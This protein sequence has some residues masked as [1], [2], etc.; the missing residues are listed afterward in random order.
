VHLFAINVRLGTGENP[1]AA[2]SSLGMTNVVNHAPA[3]PDDRLR[4]ET[5]VTSRRPSKSH[6][7]TG[8]VTFRSGLRNQHD[9]LVFSYENAA[10]I[11]CRPPAE[12]TGA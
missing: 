4:Y 3:R 1:I 7:G 10:L 2:M 6:P 11:H 8:V 5:T 9:E 12:A